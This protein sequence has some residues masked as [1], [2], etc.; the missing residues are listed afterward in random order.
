[1]NKFLCTTID[2]EKAY[3][4]LK[5]LRTSLKLSKKQLALELGISVNQVIACDKH[6]SLPSVVVLWKLCNTFQ[7]N[8]LQIIHMKL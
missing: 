6:L 2:Y 1:M 3:Q 8:P 4:T 5:R 7:V